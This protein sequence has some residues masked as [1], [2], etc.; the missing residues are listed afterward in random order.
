[1]TRPTLTTERLILRPFTLEDASRCVELAGNELISATTATIPH[2]YTLDQARA[3]ISTHEENF[4]KNLGIQFAITLKNSGELIGCIDYLGFN[5]ANK[6]AEVGYW[7]GVPYW[8]KGY[9]TEALSAM[10]K[11]GFEKLNLNKIIARHMSNNLAS[12]KVMQKCGMRQEGYLVQ[13]LIKNGKVIDVVL[14][15]INK[16]EYEK[17]RY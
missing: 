8:G 3:W 9:C 10:I 4:K 2:P 1:M 16:E 17:L 7:V 6:K 5:H 11:N 13:D 12:G 15:G 14:Y